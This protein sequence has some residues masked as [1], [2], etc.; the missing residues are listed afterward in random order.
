MRFPRLHRFHRALHVYGKLI[1]PD[2]FISVNQ[3]V[4]NIKR[5]HYASVDPCQLTIIEIIYTRRLN[6]C[7]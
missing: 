6:D 7:Y 1:S 5:P 4:I 3:N 2:T